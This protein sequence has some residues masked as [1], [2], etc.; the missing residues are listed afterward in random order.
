MSGAKNNMFEFMAEY[1]TESDIYAAKAIAKV[2]MFIYRYRKDH[3]LSQK[4][5]AKKIG[6]T[7]SMISKW[8]SSEYNFTIENIAKIAE[9]LEVN[10]N[11]EFAAKDQYLY[12]KTINN[13]EEIKY[14]FPKISRTSP[15]D[16]ICAAVVAA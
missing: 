1:I 15:K 10:F 9:K 4:D 13:Y 8:E 16:T 7:Q 2:S 11:I 3:H 6:V 5:L 12:N 14:D